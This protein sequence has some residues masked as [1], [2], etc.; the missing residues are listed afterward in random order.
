MEM[1]ILIRKGVFTQQQQFMVTSVLKIKGQ[2]ITC[3]IIYLLHCICHQMCCFREG[4]SPFV[5][6]FKSVISTIVRMAVTI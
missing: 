6:Y 4:C 5:R 1:L 3:T 2:L